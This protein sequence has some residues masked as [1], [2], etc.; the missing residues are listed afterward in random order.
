[1]GGTK[2]SIIADTVIME[3]TLRTMN[4]ETREFAQKRIVDMSENITKALRSECR[5]E[6]IR[7]SKLLKNDNEIINIV[8]NV[9]ENR[10]G[11]EKVVVSKLPEMAA[12]D[13]S[14]YLEKAKGAYFH[15]GCPNR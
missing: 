3:A 4:A 14:Y 8:R 7:G 15:L 9:A 5:V 13:F 10:L 1:M 12:E 11:K 6:I 2:N